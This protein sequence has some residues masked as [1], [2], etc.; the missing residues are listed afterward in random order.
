V[1][2]GQVAWAHPLPREEE[3]AA[4]DAAGSALVLGLTVSDER[5]ARRAE[6]AV[7]D[8]ATGE[9]QQ[10]LPLGEGVLSSLSRVGR[11]L[12]A[13]VE[14]DAMHARGPAWFGDDMVVAQPPRFRILRITG[15]P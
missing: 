5:G 6:L 10:R 11:S 2:T 15:N 14:N 7:L 8:K 13:V 4:W 12:C 9:A 1:S 3:L